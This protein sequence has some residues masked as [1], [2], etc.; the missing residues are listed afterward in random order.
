[1][2]EDLVWKGNIDA[3]DGLSAGG[4]DTDDYDIDFKTTAVMVA[5]GTSPRANTTA[6]RTTL[7]PPTG[8]LNTRSTASS[9]TSGSGRGA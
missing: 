2:V 9:P 1:V 4:K 5:G 6:S 3:G 7:S 8:A